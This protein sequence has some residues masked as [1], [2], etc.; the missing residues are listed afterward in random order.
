MKKMVSLEN[1]N[2]RNSQNLRVGEM[3]EETRK[4]LYDFFKPFNEEL[5]RLAGDQK[6]N[7]GL[8]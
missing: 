7:Y 3:M 2:V 4:I 8:T 5:A 6:F 1:I